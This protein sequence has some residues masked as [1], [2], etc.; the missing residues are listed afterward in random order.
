MRRE[1][2]PEELIACS[3]V[4]EGDAALIGNQS[5]PT[6]L[7]FCLLLKFFELEAGSQVMPESCQSLR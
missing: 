6:R 2:E 1:W 3:T 4:V 7:G 5:G